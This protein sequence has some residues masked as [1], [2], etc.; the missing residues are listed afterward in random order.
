M[1]PVIEI[2][3]VAKAYGPRGV[4]SGIDL[5]VG[6]HRA[7]ALIGAS[8]SGTSTLLRCIDSTCWWRSTMATSRST[9]R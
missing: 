9:P 7:L 4:P 6:E 8:G 1:A 3:G 5:A 2:R